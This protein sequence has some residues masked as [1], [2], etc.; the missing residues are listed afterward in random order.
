[1]KNRMGIDYNISEGFFVSAE[2]FNSTGGLDERFNVYFE[3][4]DFL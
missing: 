4:I 2:A 3:D 1:M